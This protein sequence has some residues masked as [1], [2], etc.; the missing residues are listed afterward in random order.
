VD[1]LPACLVEA[2]GLAG[3]LV[4]WLYPPSPLSFPPPYKCTVGWTMI[5]GLNIDNIEFRVCM[6][7]GEGSGIPI[8]ALVFRAPEAAEARAWRALTA[9]NLRVRASFRTGCEASGVDSLLPPSITCRHIL[10]ICAGLCCL[11]GP[12]STAAHGT[13]GRCG[14][15]ARLDHGARSR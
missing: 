8:C 15:A 11:A 4:G 7:W 1:R 3:W 9:T 10:G 14:P 5:S 2:G 13:I 12:R 6:P